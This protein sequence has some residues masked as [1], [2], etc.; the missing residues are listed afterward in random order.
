VDF[1]A[2]KHNCEVI[3]QLAFKRGAMGGARRK[4]IEFTQAALRHY[5]WKNLC[6]DRN[7]CRAMSREDAKERIEALGGKGERQRFQENGLCG[8]GQP[9]PAANMIKR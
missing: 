3:E 1:F 5:K 2:E 7:T 6:I 9:I 4:I 8:C